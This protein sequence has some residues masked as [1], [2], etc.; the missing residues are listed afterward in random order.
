M[1]R[2]YYIV[3]AGML[4]AGSSS[5]SVFENISGKKTS[6]TVSGADATPVKKDASATTA[7]QDTPKASS[8]KVASSNSEQAAQTAQQGPKP[9]LGQPVVRIDGKDTSFGGFEAPTVEAP[10]KIAPVKNTLSETARLL[11]GNWTII[12]VG[13]TNIDRDEDMPYIFFEPKEGI[14]YA[15]NGCNTLNGS[16]TLDTNKIT[17]HNVITTLRLCAE[18]TFDHEI[19]AVVNNEIASVLKFNEEGAET[20][21]NLTSPSG[22]AL[23]TLRRGNLEFLNGQWDIVAVAGLETL[24]TPATIFFDLT[25]LKLHGNTGCN[26]INGEIYLDHRVPNA[27]DFSQ[28]ITTLRACQ[29]PEQQTAIL[30]ALEET[31]SAVSEDADTVI[32]L[33]ANGMEMMR[34]KKAVNK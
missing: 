10:K 17:F 23:M 5:C 14:F 6:T 26:F 29:Y 27:V 9:A 25:D 33:D 3:A 1:K 4:L 32:L 11:G 28:I 12:K 24:R 22:K 34:L 18:V 15:N 16:F 2:L 19:N 8:E 7:N 31:A 20:F 13:E 21:L 30:V